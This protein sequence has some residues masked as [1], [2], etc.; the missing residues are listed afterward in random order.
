MTADLRRIAEAATPGPY[1]A[2]EGNF[3]SLANGHIVA[4]V[5]CCGANNAD[6]LDIAAW[7]P[8]RKLAALD[9][10]EAAERTA[11]DMEKWFGDFVKPDEWKMREWIDTIER[12]LA[13]WRKLGGE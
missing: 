12:A 2:E 11:T 10:I 7:P 3:I 6:V 5:P 13:A 8:E 4:E 1:F 9:V